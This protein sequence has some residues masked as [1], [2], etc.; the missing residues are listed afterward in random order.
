MAL[1]QDDLQLGT[2]I[3]TGRQGG[4]G[5]REG[6]KEGGQGMDGGQSYLSILALLKCRESLLY[7]IP[8]LKQEKETRP[9]VRAGTKACGER[10]DM[11]T[12]VRR[13]LG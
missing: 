1:A 5:G 12:G 4:E 9:S 3:L 13:R 11:M 8:P 7:L 2:I 6:G 10:E